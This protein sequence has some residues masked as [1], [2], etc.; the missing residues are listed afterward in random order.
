MEDNC[1][2]SPEGA[3]YRGMIVARQEG[4]EAVDSAIELSTSILEQRRNARFDYEVLPYLRIPMESG[5]FV[6]ILGVVLLRSPSFVGDSC[7]AIPANCSKEREASLANVYGYF[8]RVV[9]LALLHN[10]L[11]SICISPIR[12]Y[13]TVV[14]LS[15][16]LWGCALDPSAV[17]VFAVC[18]CMHV[19][20]CFVVISWDVAVCEIHGHLPHLSLPALS[21]CRFCR[22][23]GLRVAHKDASRMI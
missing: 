16:R 17:T 10:S 3:T 13:A 19:V 11:L 22:V 15:M 20:T 8:V 7:F 21:G 4:R 5:L 12:R 14:L 23:H 2:A 1:T 18:C 9:L 6:R